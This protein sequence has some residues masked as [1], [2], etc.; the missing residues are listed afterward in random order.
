MTMYDYEGCRSTMPSVSERE[1]SIEVPGIPAAHQSLAEDEL[2][3]VIEVVSAAA[4]AQGTPFRLNRICL[5]DRFE[6][7]VNRAEHSGGSAYAATR[8]HVRAIGKMLRVRSEQGDTAFEVIIDATQVT[9]WGLNNARCLTTVL[10]E[11]SHVLLEGRH[12]QR[13]GREE[14]T[15]SSE[16]QVPW[17][18]RWASEL[19]D[20]F[21]VDRTVDAL[22]AVLAHQDDGSP[23]SLRELEE[24]QGIDW[25]EELLAGLSQMPRALDERTSEFRT[26]TIGLDVIES[27]VIPDI[28]DLLT[29]L[30]HTAS[31]YMGTE[32]WPDIVG[33]IRGTEASRR[34]LSEHLE[35]ILDQ[36]DNRDVSYEKSVQVVA[37]ALEGVF[38]NCGFR[39]APEGFYISFDTPSR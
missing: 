26:E 4:K 25:P 29:L 11:L 16:A 33:R 7:E 12:L 31:M 30:S 28:K 1:Y 37:R 20:E 35:T 21:D 34:F 23:W 10:H 18:N 9:P 8:S 17:V 32:H 5:T 6:D 3:I 38:D 39:A 14:S 15:R 36:L 19:L 27:R 24:A 13:P 2:A 22:L